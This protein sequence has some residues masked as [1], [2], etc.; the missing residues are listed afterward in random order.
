MAMHNALAI[1]NALLKTEGNAMLAEKARKPE[2]CVRGNTPGARRRAA[3]QR[4]N[5]AWDIGK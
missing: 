2:A 4:N 3:G 1:G 5:Q